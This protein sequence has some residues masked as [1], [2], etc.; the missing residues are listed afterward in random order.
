MSFS[1][2]FPRL[3]GMR[4]RVLRAFSGLPRHVRVLWVVFGFEALM[5]GIQALRS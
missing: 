5:I 1:S 4:G 3:R 2:R